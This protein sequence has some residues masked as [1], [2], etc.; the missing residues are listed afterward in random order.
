MRGEEP[1][2]IAFHPRLFENSSS[3]VFDM[4]II[5]GF[6]RKDVKFAFSEM[7]PMNVVLI[8]GAPE[9]LGVHVAC[10]ANDAGEAMIGLAVLNDRAISMIKIVP[11]A[12]YDHDS[13]I[14]RELLTENGK[15]MLSNAMLKGI[16]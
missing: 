6:L 1:S 14:A 8:A 3:V 13:L 12:D 7:I 9:R 15:R 4:A 10:Q 5:K 16:K 11:Q 2:T